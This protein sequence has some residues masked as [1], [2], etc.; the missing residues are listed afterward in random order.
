MT[1]RFFTVD[2]PPKADPASK[3]RELSKPQGLAE[4]GVAILNRG[5]NFRFRGQYCAGNLRRVGR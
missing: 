5:S 4:G 3:R 2:V 1:K